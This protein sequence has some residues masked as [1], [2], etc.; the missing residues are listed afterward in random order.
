MAV[1]IGMDY[2]PSQYQRVEYIQGTA[3]GHLPYDYVPKASTRIVAEFSNAYND[4]SGCNL[5]GVSNDDLPSLWVRPDD[6]DT[7]VK[8]SAFGR[9]VTKTV[10]LSGEKFSLSLDRY[11]RSITVNGETISDTSTLS[12]TMPEHPI[13]LLG[14]YYS[15]EDRA[16]T[17][18][19]PVRLHSFKVYEYQNSAYVLVRHAIPCYRK[20]D[21]VVGVYD[22]KTST[23][24]PYVD[25]TPQET[26]YGHEYSGTAVKIVKGYVGEDNIARQI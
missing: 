14:V 3:D 23:F 22:L 6:E 7:V 16:W 8:I 24:Y 18:D 10:A 25:A 20:S 21:H 2:I 15:D 17:T 12:P 4:E 26:A 19:Q 13:Y 5:F 9:Y 11:V 1:Y